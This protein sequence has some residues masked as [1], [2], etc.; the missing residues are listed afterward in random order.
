MMAAAHFDSNVQSLLWASDDI[1]SETALDPTL[2]DRDRKFLTE[3]DAALLRDLGYD[4]ATEIPEP[5]SLAL[6][7]LGGLMTLRR[8]RA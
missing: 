4:V 5:G 6:L 8:R 3:L 1:L 2:R 7:G